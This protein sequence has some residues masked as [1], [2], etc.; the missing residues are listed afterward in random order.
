M[1]DHAHD[2]LHVTR[3]L[4]RSSHHAER[5][6]RRAV[7]RDEARNDRVERP[8]AAADFV[9]MIALERKAG[10]A[11]LQAD[12]G[13]RHDDA[14][15]ESHVVRLDQRHHHAGLVGCAKVHGA[16]ARRLAGTDTIARARDRSVARVRA[17][18]RVE[19]CLRRRRSSSRRRS[20]SDAR[21]RTRASS[22]RSADAGWR[23]NRRAAR[24]CRTTAACRAPS[25]P[26]CLVR[27]AESRGR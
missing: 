2:R 20:H 13:A 23:P 11:I 27:S 15:S 5:R 24:R 16:A 1:V 6:Q 14:G 19:Q 7:A 25:A 18:S 17:D 10:A 4:D 12:A 26:Q 3:R 9:R 8:L 22:L 21:R